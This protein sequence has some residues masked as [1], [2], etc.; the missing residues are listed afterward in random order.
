MLVDARQLSES[1]AGAAVVGFVE[2]NEIQI[3]SVAGPRA[4]KWTEGC[5]FS[6]AVVGG[7]IAE[8]S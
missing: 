5:E 2:K 3:L 6:L 4:S 8:L 7:M 1:E